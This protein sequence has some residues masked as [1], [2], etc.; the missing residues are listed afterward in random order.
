MNQ[1]MESCKRRNC[2]RDDV[3][4]ELSDFMNELDDGASI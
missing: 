3:I 2:I 4:I 1:H